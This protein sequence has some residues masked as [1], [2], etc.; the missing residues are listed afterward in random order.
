MRAVVQR[1]AEAAVEVEGRTV[2]RIGPGL[3]ILL[4]VRN[5]DTLAEVQTLADKC[6]DLRLFADELGKM[7]RSVLEVAGSVLVVSQFTLYGDCRKGRR[8]S[9]IE[10][11]PPVI[12]QPLYEAFLAAV[13]QRGVVTAQ[14]VF[15]AKMKVRLLNDGPVTVIVEK[16]AQQP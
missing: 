5:G 16:D 2:G 14:G 15:G 12:S 9:F 1:V 7:N 3:V 10:A 13:A 11:A 8:P 4:G 6:V